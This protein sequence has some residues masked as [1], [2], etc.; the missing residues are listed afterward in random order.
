MHAWYVTKP[1]V[2]VVG[3]VL[4]ACMFVFFLL[5]PINRPDYFKVEY[6]FYFK[7][8]LKGSLRHTLWSGNSKF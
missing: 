6:Q 3:L 7:F 2:V 5:I 8:Y 1:L 4:F